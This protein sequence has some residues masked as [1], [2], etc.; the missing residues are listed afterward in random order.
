MTMPGQ[1]YAGDF[2]DQFSARA[3][4]VW[5]LGKATKPSQITMKDKKVMEK[6]I[7]SLEKENKTI[8]SKNQKLEN[9]LSTLMARLER[10]EKVAL[11][12]LKSKDL[13]VYSLK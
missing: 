6:K 9:K 13:A 8:L 10:L 3:G 1:D 4:F 12:D 7:E 11:G 2:E 5:K